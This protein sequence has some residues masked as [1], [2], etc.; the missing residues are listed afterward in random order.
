MEGTL[1]KGDLVTFRHPFASFP[2]MGRIIAIGKGRVLVE[3]GIR[4][5]RRNPVEAVTLSRIFHKIR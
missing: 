5:Q 1:K 2:R 3:T 4:K